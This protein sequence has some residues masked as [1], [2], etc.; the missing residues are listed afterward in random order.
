MTKK[1]LLCFFGALLCFIA[2]MPTSSG[3]VAED[4]EIA[5]VEPSF[6]V[7]YLKYVPASDAAAK[8]RELIPEVVVSVDERLNS[9]YLKGSDSELNKVVEILQ[10]FDASQENERLAPRKTKKPE[11][12]TQIYRPE[13]IDPQEAVSVLKEAAVTGTKT[14]AVATGNSILLRSADQTA[15]EE[16]LTILEELDQGP[17]TP[18]GIQSKKSRESFLDAL[19]S[20][21]GKGDPPEK[22]QNAQLEAFRQRQAILL[23]EIELQR[24]R[25]NLL[26]ERVKQREKEMTRLLSQSSAGNNSSRQ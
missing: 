7:F 8:L 1:S 21:A 23:K 24:A 15:I 2:M 20:N 26:E 3:Q 12:I 18:P 22:S 25:L 13:F 11:T 19:L 16:I 10:V 5:K 14:Y 17:V 4:V 6:Q 9:L